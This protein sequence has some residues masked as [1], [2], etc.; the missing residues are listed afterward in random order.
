[1]KYRCTNKNAPNYSRY[2]ARGIT[3]CEEWLHYDNFKRDMIDT[4][5]DDLTLDRIDNNKGYCKDNCRWI[6]FREQYHNTRVTADGLIGARKRNK[7][8]ATIMIN[9][10]DHYLGVFNT[11]EEAT[12][13]YVSVYTKTY[14]KAPL[15]KS[16][17][18][19]FLEH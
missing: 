4:Y 18:G 2:G 12:R 13:A 11:R 16:Q 5:S 10:I 3:V 1:M 8:A 14:N 17:C 7:F 15:L 6:S 9:G 19:T